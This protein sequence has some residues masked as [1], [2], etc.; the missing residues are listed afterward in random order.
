VVI[1]AANLQQLVQQ[2]HLLV[3]RPSLAS[4]VLSI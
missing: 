2:Q 3:G 4:D 1:V